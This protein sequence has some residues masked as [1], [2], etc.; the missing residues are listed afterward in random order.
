MK[1][2]GHRRSDAN[3]WWPHFTQAQLEYDNGWRTD[4]QWV[5][6]TTNRAAHPYRTLRYDPVTGAPRRPY[7]NAPRIR[8]R[9]SGHYNTVVT[10]RK[11]V[12][13]RS[14]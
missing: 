10:P 11:N 8:V 12:G 14:T 5:W 4:G 13:T 1:E 9:F 7:L 3:A 2:W 6:L